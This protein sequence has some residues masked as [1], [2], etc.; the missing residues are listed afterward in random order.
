MGDVYGAFGGKGLGAFTDIG[1]LTMFADYRVP[2]VLKVLGILSYS[3]ALESC[4]Q[5]QRE[6]PAGSDPECEIRAATIV[7][8]EHIR[9]RLAERLQKS[10]S[11][12]SDPA[13][14]LAIH[15]DWQLW[16]AGERSRAVHPPHHRTRTIY[17]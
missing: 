3:D 6:V 1:Q 7:A 14:V 17:Y 5:D 4:I 10:G 11:L 8:V 9:Q 15:I 12:S 16:E 2:V 13:D